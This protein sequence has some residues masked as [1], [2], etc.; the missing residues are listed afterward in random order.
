MLA[1]VQTGRRSRSARPSSSQSSRP[2]SQSAAQSSQQTRWSS[3]LEAAHFSA[4]EKASCNVVVS[5]ETQQQPAA[6]GRRQHLANDLSPSRRRPEESGGGGGDFAFPSAPVRSA[7]E[8]GPSIHAENEKAGRPLSALMRGAKSP[9]SPARNSRSS[10]ASAQHPHCCEASQSASVSGDSTAG[11]QR[12]SRGKAFVAAHPSPIS[13]PAPV[14]N[15]VSGDCEP[16]LGDGEEMG[17]VA[18]AAP[19]VAPVEGLMELKGVLANLTAARATAATGASGLA[20]RRKRAQPFPA[21]SADASGRPPARVLPVPSP[22]DA[23]SR[24]LRNPRRAPPP[25]PPPRARRTAR[26]ECADAEEDGHDDMESQ[27]HSCRPF[28]L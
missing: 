4:P 6:A 23:A 12:H 8:T 15:S 11:S 25:L 28:F 18:D 21:A 5:Q 9:E 20:S 10:S 13:E 1:R 24:T 2:P 22:R 16:K 26:G 17:I 14:P 3:S 27:V 7:T 19:A